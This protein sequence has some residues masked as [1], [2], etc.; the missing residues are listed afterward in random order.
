M[1]P[2]SR[3]SLVIGAAL[4]LA[5]STISVASAIAG[6]DSSN[7]PKL[8][9][10]SGFTPLHDGGFTLRLPLRTHSPAGIRIVQVTSDAY[11]EP[12]NFEFTSFFGLEDTPY[13]YYSVNE[14]RLVPGVPGNLRDLAY[15]D[16]NSTMGSESLVIFRRDR[17]HGLLR[18]LIDRLPL[19]RRL[20]GAD[21]RAVIEYDLARGL[22]LIR[23]MNGYLNGYSGFSYTEAAGLV[24]KTENGKYTIYESDVQFSALPRR[25]DQGLKEILMTRIYTE[26]GSITDLG[27]IEAAY[28][29]ERFKTAKLDGGI[30]V[31][32]ANM[33]VEIGPLMRTADL[34]TIPVSRNVPA[35]AGP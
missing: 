16:F 1:F 19:N 13:V 6:Q 27:E 33:L 25:N 7:A 34:R 23:E 21:R 2:S 17:F 28:K 18:I 8:M 4:A 12:L 10:F 35:K 29:V 22:F 11:F 24:A 26:Q 9:H 15:Y 14:A 32:L 5:L 30:F 3:P 20:D 31:A